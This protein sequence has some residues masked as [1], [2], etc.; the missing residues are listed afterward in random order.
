MQELILPDKWVSRSWIEAEYFRGVQA[1][2]K[3]NASVSTDAINGKLTALA[4]TPGGLAILGKELRSPLLR[5]MLYESVIRNLFQVYKLTQG[6]T[7]DF[8]ADV[9]VPAA[10]IGID[11]LPVQ[12]E[13]K[14]DRA[15]VDTRLYA[16]NPYVRWNQS[17]QTKFDILNAVQQR[18]KA[19]LMLQEAS[20]GFRVIRYASGL[21]SGQGTTAGLENTPAA[22]QNAAT[23]VPTSKTG[24]LSLDQLATG[25]SN[26][27]DRLIDGPKK[28]WIAPSRMAD[29]ITFNFAGAG[30]PGGQGYFAPNTQEILLQKGFIGS[31]MGAEVFR[32]I[33]VPKLD[34]GV[35]TDSKAGT[36]SEDIMGYLLGPAD[37]LGLLAIRTDLSIETLK[38]ATRFADV[39]AGWMDSGYFIRWVK[40]LQRLVNA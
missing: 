10:S 35:T 25:I 9:A 30:N 31:I 38:D 23:S 1:A 39:F 22:S 40:A 2:Q 34:T 16:A 3:L 8:W 33:V 29:L 19:S 13:I 7:A 17:N 20:A 6:E 24:F 5:E 27:G 37:L 36:G 11:G 28:L 14:S 15:I 12:V 4:A 32:D 21:R 18:M 26:F